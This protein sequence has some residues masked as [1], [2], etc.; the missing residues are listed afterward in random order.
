MFIILRNRL[1]YALNGSD[2]TKILKDKDINVRVDNKPRRDKGFPTG[3]MDVV[4]I[5]KTGE[6]FRVL[7]DAKGRFVLKKISAK[8]AEFKLIKI[9]QKSFGPNKIPYIVGHDAKTI[10]FPHPDINL[11][12]TVQINLATNK[13]MSVL[14][15]ETGNTSIIKGGNNIGRVGIIQK[16][17]KHAGAVN[18]IHL[19]DANGHEFATP[20]TN[21]F[22]IGKGKNSLIELPKGDGL[23]LSA[24]DEKKRLSI[25]IKE[26]LIKPSESEDL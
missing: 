24:L 18:I 9:T 3:I 7:Y 12:D 8:E 20:S 4:S 11:E 13:V 14:R 22:A 26:I 21:V 17:E 10:R 2:V 15:L 19:K 5:E 23:W 25:M 6:S 16:I 1:R